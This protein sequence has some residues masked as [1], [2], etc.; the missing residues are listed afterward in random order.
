MELLTEAVGSM[1]PCAH[2]DPS[3]GRVSD[4]LSACILDVK[5][6]CNVV[7]GYRTFLKKMDGPKNL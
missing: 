4:R 2:S 1:L 5:H 6:T 7:H 3:A